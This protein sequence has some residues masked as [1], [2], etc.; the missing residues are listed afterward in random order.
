MIASTTHKRWIYSPSQEYIRHC[1][2]AYIQRLPVKTHT[3]HMYTGLSNALLQ[4][5]SLSLPHQR[6][7]DQ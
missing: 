7:P 6:L 1:C 2:Q 3:E 5:S 4:V